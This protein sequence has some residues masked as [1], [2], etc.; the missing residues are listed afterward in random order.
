MDDLEELMGELYDP[1]KENEYYMNCDI[2]V[3]QLEKVK[4]TKSLEKFFE[5]PSMFKYIRR[6]LV[7]EAHVSIK[8]RLFHSQTIFK[9]GDIFG[10]GV[11]KVFLALVFPLFAAHPDPH[12]MAIVIH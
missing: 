4:E 3:L 8:Q 5:S 6:L 1:G 9:I 2:I 11:P 7:D 12:K 10:K